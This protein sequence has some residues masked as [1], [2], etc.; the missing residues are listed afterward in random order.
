M[1]VVLLFFI[2]FLFVNGVSALLTNNATTRQDI[3]IFFCFTLLFVFLG[4]RDIPILNDTAHYYEHQLSVIA[5]HRKKIFEIDH[6]E[7]FEEG[8]QIYENLIA[9]ISD[10]PYSIICITAFIITVSYLYFIKSHTSNVAYVVFFHITNGFLN[11]YSGL[12]QGLATCFFLFAILALEKRRLWIYFILCGLAY[13]FHSSAFILFFIP[14][15]DRIQIN[16]RN[17]IWTILIV[18]LAMVQ[19]ES[20]LQLGGR[21]DSAYIERNMSRSTLAFASIINSFTYILTIGMC[22]FLKRQ[23]Q[24]VLTRT[25]HYLWWLSIFSAAFY[26]LDTQFLI[27][28]RFTMYFSLC[29]YILLAKYIFMS[30]R[31][32]RRFFLTFFCVLLILRVFII[33]EYR[34]EWWHIYPYSFF[35]F[36]VSFHDTN[37]GY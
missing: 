34:P 28:A 26:L 37:T 19:I 10:N 21:G 4:F 6:F 12:R 7:R 27:M 8:Y 36:D 9:W 18:L 11:I 29:G 5:L 13:S 30:K 20:V 33:L 17:I 25:D 22:Y 2:S 1:L 14:I 16:R 35:D 23:N 32:Q 24:I 3:Q 15:L 31:P